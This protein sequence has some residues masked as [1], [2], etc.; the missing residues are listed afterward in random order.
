MPLGLLLQVPQEERD[1]RAR[2]EERDLV[3]AALQV[4]QEE[5]D[6]RARPRAQ[7]G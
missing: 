5:R 4:P 7:E 3:D 1:L 6:L 2:Q